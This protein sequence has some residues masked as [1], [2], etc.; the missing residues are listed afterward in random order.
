MSSLI[1]SFIDLLAFTLWLALIAR[2]LMSWLNVTQSGPLYPIAAIIYQ[3][4]EPIL[5]P[6]RRILP[7]FGM[8]DFSPM[9][10]LLLIALVRQ[11][12]LPL[13]S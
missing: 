2:V 9:I 5:A 7:R 10:A 12:L 11:F 13:A 4:T 1:V 3:I 6:I 8:F